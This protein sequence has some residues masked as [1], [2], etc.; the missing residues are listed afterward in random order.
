MVRLL[1]I[2]CLLAGCSS[3]PFAQG[4]EHFRLGE[5]PQAISAWSAAR[6]VSD[7]P[8]QVE[9]RIAKARF[10][11]LVVRC[12]EEVRTW[13]TDNAQVLL[14]ALSEKYSDHPLVED[15]HSR[16]ARKI[17]A[18]FFKEG[19]DRLEADAPQ[20]AIEYF[21]K[22]LAWVEDHPG[23][24]A[25]L[26]KA[27]AQVLH[28]EALGEEL[29][30]EGLG[31]LR[32]GNNVRAKAAFAHATAI[33]GDESRS[34]ILLAELSEDIGREKIRTGKIWMERGLFGPAWVVLREGFRMIPEDE[35]I[36]ALLSWL[37]G[38]LHAQREIQVADMEVRKGLTYEAEGRLDLIE[39]A[40]GEDHKF[41]IEAL[42]GRAL[43]RRNHDR[44]LL[45]RACELDYQ[46][47]RAAELYSAIL[48]EMGPSGF[49]DVALRSSGL[50]K[51]LTRAEVFFKEALLAEA[52]GDIDAYM[53]KLAA[54]IREAADYKDAVE[55]F[56]IVFQ[57]G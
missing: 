21:V 54:T 53:E 34:A 55:R 14:R 7:D 9:E 25:G 49:E 5:Y 26:A 13:R 23:A 6:N 46:I 20:L 40:V 17:A 32:L 45:G 10:M 35:E 44:Y 56:T 51:R 42:R 43:D 28:R 19:T 12:R 3:A 29:H 31:E 37:A 41:E 11:A 36:Q 47:V 15:L 50:A 24:A 2:L 4:D 52:E 39:G 33:L 27:S 18:E 30:F 38:E 16:T 22:A 8:V 48:L 1:I 57:E